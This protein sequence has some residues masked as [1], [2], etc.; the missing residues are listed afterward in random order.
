MLQR[1]IGHSIAEFQQENLILIHPSQ[2]QCSH[3]IIRYRNDQLNYTTQISR[4]LLTTQLEEIG[5]W[6][7]RTTTQRPWPYLWQLETK[8]HGQIGGLHG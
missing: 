5:N 6:R 8:N 1:W 4:S 7:K 3:I 2:R